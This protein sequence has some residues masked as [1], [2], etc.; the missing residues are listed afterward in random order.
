[1]RAL[2]PE[3]WNVLQEVCDTLSTA[4]GI[5]WVGVTDSES[6]AGWIA[7]A[8][9]DSY[10]PL[11]PDPDQQLREIPNSDPDIGVVELV[12]SRPGRAF[13][14]GMLLSAG[15]MLIAVPDLAKPA[16]FG[17]AIEGILDALRRIRRAIPGGINTPGGT[18][19]RQ[20]PPLAP[21]QAWDWLPVGHLDRKP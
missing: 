11:R 19:P 6:A 13:A 14:C 12:P 7:F 20:P 18:P 4:P 15:L 16:E 21:L 5:V 17:L 8:G 3:E 1:M 9:A 2:H 10:A